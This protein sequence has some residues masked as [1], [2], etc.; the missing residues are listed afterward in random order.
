MARLATDVV[1]LAAG[2]VAAAGAAADVLARLDLVA[3]E[4]RDETGALLDLV[5]VAQEDGFA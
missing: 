1:V 4:E 3:A 5:L 2:R